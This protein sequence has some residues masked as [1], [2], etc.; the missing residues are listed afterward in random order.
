MNVASELGETRRNSANRAALVSDAPETADT[1]ICI[2]EDS[3][4]E[5]ARC[6]ATK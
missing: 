2:D 4:S 5:D 3:E 1:D 6:S